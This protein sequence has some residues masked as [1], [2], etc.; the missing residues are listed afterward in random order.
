MVAQQRIEVVKDEDWRGEAKVKEGEHVKVVTVLIN[1][2]G[3]S[4]RV[5]RTTQ[6]KTQLN[7]ITR[8]RGFMNQTGQE[9]DQDYNPCLIH[10]YLSFLSF[11][12]ER[13]I[14]KIRSF[15]FF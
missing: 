6:I 1:V 12:K 5:V 3:A 11:K 14:R 2:K 7:G 4:A 9:R 13:K 10:S 8:C 15:I